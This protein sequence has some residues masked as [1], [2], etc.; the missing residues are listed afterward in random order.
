MYMMLLALWVPGLTHF[1]HRLLCNNEFEGS[2]PVELTRPNLQFEL[3]CD[4]NLI[5]SVV[6]GIGCLNRKCGHR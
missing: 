4:E 3:Q 6:A 1:S 2:I 5:S